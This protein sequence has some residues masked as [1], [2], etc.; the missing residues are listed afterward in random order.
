MCLVDCGLTVSST[1]YNLIVDL[2]VS[3]HYVKL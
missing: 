2:F 1:K 3:T